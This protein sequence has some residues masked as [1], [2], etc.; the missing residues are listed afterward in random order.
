[1]LVIYNHVHVHYMKIDML[2]QGPTN[3]SLSQVNIK[4]FDM[5]LMLYKSLSLDPHIIL[6]L[7]VEKDCITYNCCILF[8]RFL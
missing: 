4:S 7:Y 6:L 1:M 8:R 2:L 3:I 5:F